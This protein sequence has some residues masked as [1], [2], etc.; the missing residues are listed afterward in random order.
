MGDAHYAQQTG[1][2]TFTVEKAGLAYLNKLEIEERLTALLES[3]HGRYRLTYVPVDPKPD[4]KFRRIKVQCSAPGAKRMGK[5]DVLTRSGYYP[6][7][8]KLK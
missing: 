5:L 1:G 4:G 2:I 7:V 6:S 8:A 3:L